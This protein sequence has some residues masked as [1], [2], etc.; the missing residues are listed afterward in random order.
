M[1]SLATLI[2]DGNRW[3][4][5]AHRQITAVIRSQYFTGLQGESDGAAA[6]IFWGSSYRTKPG[7]DELVESA[8]GSLFL[9]A[10]LCI[11]AGVI[12]PTDC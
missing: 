11:L 9:M 5:Y 4:A 2:P 7:T 8:W 1:L 6:G 12:E 10:A 3:N